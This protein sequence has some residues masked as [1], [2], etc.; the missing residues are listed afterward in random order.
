MQRPK[1]A[2]CLA[3][4]FN[5]SAVKSDSARVT[6][7]GF[8]TPDLTCSAYKYK[9]ALHLTAFGAGSPWDLRLMSGFFHPQ[10]PSSN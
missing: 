3:W 4:T 2:I 7:W 9:A 10:E 6:L 8:Q 5:G 1:A